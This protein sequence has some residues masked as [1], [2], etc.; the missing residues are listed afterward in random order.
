[1]GTRI[2]MVS[3]APPLGK[4][5]RRG[6]ISMSKRAAK[7]CL[8]LAGIQPSDLELVIY[9]G[10]YRDD[11]IGEPSIASLLQKEIGANPTLYPLDERTF[12]FDLNAGG[13]GLVNAF[14]LIDGFITSGKLKRGMVITGDS[15][16]VRGL[17]ESFNFGSAASAVILSKSQNGEGFQLIKTYSFPQYCESFKSYIS[18]KRK[19]GRI[20][21]KNVLV[22]EQ[23]DTYLHECVECCNDSLEKFLEVNG[24][25]LRDIDLILPSQSPTGIVSELEKR[26]GNPG[27]LVSV[28]SHGRGEIHTSGPAFALRKVWETGQ[29]QKARNV[30]F[31]TVG[32]GISTAIAWYRKPGLE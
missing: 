3:I 21:K 19:N 2:E 18:W 12:S 13:C 23:K 17:S 6:T 27:C 26:L 15:E 25:R 31:L 16:P 1:M 32:A 8:D 4:R 30:L 24:L 22:V 9:S 20:W 14:Q 10:I 28:N 29:F 5:S 11:H 7:S